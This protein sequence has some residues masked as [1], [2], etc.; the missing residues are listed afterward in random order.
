MAKVFKKSELPH[1]DSTR[2]GRSRLDLVTENVPVG[3]SKIR[4]D[5]VI[6]H[7]SDTCAKHY[8]I[9]AYHLFVMLEGEATIKTPVF[10]GTFKEGEAAVVEPEEVHWFENPTDQNFRFVEFWAP[11]PK[12]TVWII[13][14]DV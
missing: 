8:H 9:G 4:A 3:A 5:R 2:D 1:L 6:Y 13:E 11:P 12:E 10:E 7:P 14:D